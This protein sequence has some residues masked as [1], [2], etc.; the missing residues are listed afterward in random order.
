MRRRRG[1]VR[2]RVQLLVA[3]G[4][5]AIFVIITEIALSLDPPG[6]LLSGSLLLATWLWVQFVVWLV[7]RADLPPGGRP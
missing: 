7:Q 5:A 6:V 3:L 2:F 1:N 4:L